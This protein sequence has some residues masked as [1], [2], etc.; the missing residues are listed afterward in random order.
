MK[1]YGLLCFSNKEVLQL[2][3][4]VLSINFYRLPSAAHNQLA[5]TFDQISDPLHN[6]TY[7]VK[8]CH[9]G[10]TRLLVAE[11]AV[12]GFTG[13][14]LCSYI[15]RIHRKQS[16]LSFFWVDEIHKQLIFKQTLNLG[17]CVYVQQQLFA[18]F[19]R[20]LTE[21]LFNLYKTSV[22]ISFKWLF[23]H[24]TVCYFAEG[25]V[26]NYFSLGT[27]TCTS[28]TPGIKMG[29]VSHNLN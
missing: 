2:F 19:T 27:V 13:L 12:P 28:F 24:L 11:S 23:L 21:R 5:A 18:F 25:Y 8:D 7:S 17:P 9:R 3:D 16:R 29:P 10:K 15:W 20:K 6:K 1:T 4:T 26:P 22:N 14:R